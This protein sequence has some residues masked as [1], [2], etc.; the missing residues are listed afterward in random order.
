MELFE[1]RLTKSIISAIWLIIKLTDHFPQHI[2]SKCKAVI[3]ELIKKKKIK[4]NLGKNQLLFIVTI[5]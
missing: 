5:S 2:W 4:S 3:E 1:K